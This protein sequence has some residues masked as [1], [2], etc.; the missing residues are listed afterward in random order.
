MKRDTVKWQIQRELEKNEINYEVIS[1]PTCITI[2]FNN[3]HIDVR[4]VELVIYT[5]DTYTII[6]FSNITLIEKAS[7][8]LA[9]CTDIGIDYYVTLNKGGIR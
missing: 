7:H 4:E 3:I 9:I 1:C 8:D 6:P 5:S 2:H